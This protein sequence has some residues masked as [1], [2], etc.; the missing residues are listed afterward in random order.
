MVRVAPGDAALARARSV[1]A[2]IGRRVR[3]VA[4]R[5]LQGRLSCTVGMG[6]DA[7]DRLGQPTRP[8]QLH[9][10]AAVHGPAHTAVA[11]PG[12]LL[13]HLRAA[14][15]DLCFALERLLL[16]ALGAAITVVDEGQG[17]RSFDA[18]D[19]LGFVDGTQH[20]TGAALY[21]ATLIG[22]ENPDFAGGAY[23][24]VQQYRHNLTAWGAL[25]V[26]EQEPMIGRTKADNVA[27]DDGRG[28]GR[29][30]HTSLTTIVDA[31]GTAR[32]ILRD[33]MPFG[34]PG[35]GELGA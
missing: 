33:N 29:R 17:F 16:D 7:W 22:D 10:F 2:A 9:A 30:S 26:A 19:L 31:D 32:H 21:H 24:V 18:R 35:R 34:R 12:D 23:V 5:D 14:R 1:I 27:L 20:P 28:T 11:T 3:T 25:A 15:S 6:R 8:R 4:S 13:F